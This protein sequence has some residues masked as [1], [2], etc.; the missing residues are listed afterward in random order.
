MS[1][2]TMMMMMMSGLLYPQEEEEDNEDE[3]PIDSFETIPDTML[4]EILIRLSVKDLLRCTCVSKS[5]YNLIKSPSFIKLHLNHRKDI[6]PKLLLFSSPL[7]D[8]LLYIR[9][10]D[11]QCMEFYKLELPHMISKFYANWY[12]VSYSLICVSTI[13]GSRSLNHG[14]DIY[15]WNPLI[16]RCRT[17]PYLDVSHIFLHRWAALAFGYVPL[18]SDFQVVLIVSDDYGK[19]PTFFICVYSLNTNS[20]KTKTILDDLS[21]HLHK[22]LDSVSVNGISCWIMIDREND[23]ETLVCFDSM[24]DV[25]RKVSLPH[26][27]NDSSLHQLLCFDQSVALFHKE[28]K[29]NAF[30]M[31]VLKQD[32]VKN[33]F[34]WEKKVS[35][36]LEKHI[37]NIVIGTRNNRELIFKSKLHQRGLITYNPETN[38]VNEFVRSWKHWST[39]GI[40]DLF[41]TLIPFLVDPFVDGLVLLDTD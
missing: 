25:L 23:V 12:A 3:T 34:F 26:Q 28:P 21:V 10:N 5:W 22:E 7:H 38:K 20:W 13:F 39:L 4:S 30:D 15:L 9:T 16:Q 31:W 35:V 29:L 40:D 17:L 32:S 18:I 1:G 41:S 33:D 14:W 36:T 8:K 2:L 11:E 27:N 37:H 19:I 24:N 6:A